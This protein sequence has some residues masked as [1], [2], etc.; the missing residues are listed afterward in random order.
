M[1]LL[2]IGSGG[3]EHAPFWKLAQSPRVADDRR[4]EKLSLVLRHRLS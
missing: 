4:L 3:R 2:G 1:K